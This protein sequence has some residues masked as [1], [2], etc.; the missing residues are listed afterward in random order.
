MSYRRAWLLVEAVNDGLREPA[1]VAET[2]GKRGG[3][4]SLTAV[5]ARVV[6]LYRGIEAQARTASA[7]EIRSLVQLTRRQP[8]V[9]D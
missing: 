3:G 9:I 6:D 2:G 7:G 4:A 1:V 8:K 5:G